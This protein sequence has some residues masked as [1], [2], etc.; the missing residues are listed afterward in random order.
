MSTFI[1]AIDYYLPSNIVNTRAM[2]AETQPERLGFTDKIIEDL[3]GIKEVRHASE[4]E[5]PSTLAS[6]AANK[7]LSKF[8]GNP[9]EIDL[10]IFCGIDRDY[11]EPST[12]HIIQENLGL[13]NAVCFDVSNACLGFMT[14]MNIANAAITS[15]S[16]RHVMICTG[17][18]P[19]SISKVTIPHLRE[20]K[21]RTEFFNKIGA[22]TVGDAGVA[23]IISRSESNSEIKSLNFSSNG[24]L[25]KLCYYKHD[26]GVISEGQMLMKE[27]S[28]A[29]LDAHREL[30]PQT[31]KN[32]AIKTE[33]IDCLITHQ[34]GKRPWER[35]PK[36][37]GVEKERMTKTFDT[38]GN[39][40]SATFGIN[41]AMALESGKIRSGDLVMA[42]MAGS[43][44]SVCQVL[45][46][47]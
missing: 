30:L 11:I 17:E 9:D 8:N 14:G 13:R 39:I 15:G 12:A 42:A 26:R 46:I 5:K 44:L 24:Q 36:I 23:A 20:L 29:I 22:L 34:V 10:L 32:A 33:D 25:S 41:Y 16:A 38:L 45:L 7:A 31:L 4:N 19:S 1:S 43:G 18:R 47:V 28:N 21:D 27:I 40:T 6:N 37:M 2:M 35:Y 3:I